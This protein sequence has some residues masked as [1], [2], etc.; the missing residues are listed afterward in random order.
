VIARFTAGPGAAQADPK[1]EKILLQVKQP[2]PN[3]NGGGVAFG[4]DGYLYLALGDGGSFGDP[5]N[6]AQSP[7]TLLGKLLRIDVNQGDP[8]AAPP[9][10]PYARGGGLPEIWA[11]GLRNPWRFSFD[12]LTGDLYIGDVGQDQWEEID[13]LPAGSPGGTNFGWR[14]REGTHAYTGRP[15]LGVSLVDPVWEYRHDEGC[16]VTGGFVYRGQKFSTLQGTYIYGDYCIGTVWGLKRAAN[17][18]WQNQVFAKVKA[19]ISSFGQDLSGELY[20]LD[21]NGNILKLENT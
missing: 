2:Y 3:H 21:H 15:P 5:Q 1:S 10:N 12:R 9:T 8:Y 7:D 14:Y 11:I 19:S 20:L 18:A 4:P 13:F 16:S 17:G 6:R